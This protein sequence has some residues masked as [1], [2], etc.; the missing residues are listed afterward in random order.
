MALFLGSVSVA[1]LHDEAIA[2]V[3][4]RVFADTESIKLHYRS[5]LVAR[6]ARLYP[7][8]I[9][10]LFLFVTTTLTSQMMATSAAGSFQGIPWNGP[11]SI[12][13]AVANVLML[14]GLD[15]GKLSWN[16]PAWSISVEF[17]AYLVFP[18][19]LP[20]V[21]RASNGGKLVSV[22]ILIIALLWLV[23]LTKD[24]FN[25]WDGLITLLRCLPEF[26]LGTLLYQAFRRNA[27][28]SWINGDAVTLSIL[29]AVL[30]CLHFGAPDLLIVSLFA[31]LIPIAVA[32]TGRL[33]KAANV[34]PLIWLGEISYSLYL[35][36]G[37]IKFGTTKLLAAFGIQN[38]AELSRSGS[39]ALMLVMVAVC[40][41]V[42]TATYSGIEVTWRRHLRNLLGGRQKFQPVVLLGSPRA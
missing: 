41:I 13:A 34:G 9:F 21:W 42:A 1:R 39:L 28:N 25:Q 33:S 4:Y 2:A 10:V 29:G 37:F 24:N 17:M 15:A 40:L 38:S 32:N 18:L 16:Y 22:L 3:Y 26:L 14:Q 5:F 8:H 6:V 36:H 20:M 30:L 23:F 31:V 35:I 27:Q 11:E 19:A 12:T 7:M